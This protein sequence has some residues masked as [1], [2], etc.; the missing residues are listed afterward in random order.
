MDTATSASDSPRVSI[1]IKAFNEERNIVRAVESALTAISTVGGEVILADSNSTDQTVELALKYPIR[2]VRLVDA[3]DRRCGVGPQLGYQHAKGE[4]VYILDGDMR[5]RPGFLEQALSFMESRP[6]VAGVGG[7]LVEQNTD[8]LEYRAREERSPQHKQPGRVDRLDGGGLYRRR[9]IEEVGYLSNRNL[10]S[11]EEFDI[12]ARLRTRN[13]QL[14]RLPAT[15][16]D[17][18][19]HE[20]PPYRLLSH[21]WA[22]RYICGLGELVKAAA[23]KPHARLVFQELRELRLYAL[24]LAWWAVLASIP[25]LPAPMLLKLA[26]FMGLAVFPAAAMAVKKG[27]LQ[28]GAYSVVSWCF[29]TAGFI[30]GLVLSQRPV[31]QP[32]A[33]IVVHD[34]TRPTKPAFVVDAIEKAPH[35][36][37]NQGGPAFIKQGK[38]PVPSH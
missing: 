15:A 14:W 29:N 24:V 36:A 18:Y 13:W 25:F 2:I 23:G 12:A 17:H 31:D 8:S 38:H 33:A 35:Y 28:G 4:F 19:G 30:R 21:R 10:H 26:I 32:V 6:D 34:K 27:S 16:V 37:A 11:Y 9:A 22:S 20:T 3:T 5:M 1:I 7:L